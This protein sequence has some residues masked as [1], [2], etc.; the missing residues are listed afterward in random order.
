MN[1]MQIAAWL[2]CSVL[3][4]V[5]IWMVLVFTVQVG[6]TLWRVNRGEGSIED[7]NG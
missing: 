7:E 2:V 1:L 5:V 4:V 3:A 6:V